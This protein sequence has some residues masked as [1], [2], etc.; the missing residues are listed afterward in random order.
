MRARKNAGQFA[1]EVL[2]VATP[3]INERLGKDFLAGE[4]YYPAGPEEYGRGGFSS[5]LPCRRPGL[6]MKV[7]IDGSEAFLVEVLRQLGPMPGLPAYVGE[8]MKLECSG[9]PV[10][11]VWRQ[12][13]PGPSVQKEQGRRLDQIN[14]RYD[15]FELMAIKDK[16]DRRVAR[17]KRGALRLQLGLDEIDLLDAAQ[18]CGLAVASFLVHV[19]E[20]GGDVQEFQRMLFGM[21]AW[22]ERNF[23]PGPSSLAGGW[24]YAKGENDMPVKETAAVRLLGYEYHLSVLA[25]GKVVPDLAQSLLSLLQMGVFIADVQPDNVSAGVTPY[26][27][28]DGG[29]TLPLTA[30]WNG[31]W[32]DVGA[33]PQ[34]WW[35]WKRKDRAMESWAFCGT[36]AD[37]ETS[38]YGV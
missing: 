20:K 2:R 32:E 30:R 37:P 34:R 7:T 27:L 9:E 21:R 33:L 12:D 35:D 14:A 19:V 8:A 29:F 13:L 5:V 31:L 10:W 25:V 18:Q 16:T 28:F 1:N 4:G 22:A 23:D 6:V 24:R 15:L 3:T 11:I 26:T 17:G 36:G 38:R